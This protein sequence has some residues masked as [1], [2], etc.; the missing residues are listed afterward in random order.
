[1]TVCTFF[2][3]CSKYQNYTTINPIFDRPFW[4]FL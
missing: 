3:Q 4:L 2:N 1:M